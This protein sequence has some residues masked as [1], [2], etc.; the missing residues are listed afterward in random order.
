MLLFSSVNVCQL[1]FLMRVHVSCCPC[2][3]N[4]K[5]DYV[6]MAMTSGIRTS[7]IRAVTSCVKDVVSRSL[8]QGAS[9][10]GR[11]STR[12]PRAGSDSDGTTVAAPGSARDKLFSRRS[13]P[14]AKLSRQQVT[15]ERNGLI[16]ATNIDNIA[17]SRSLVY[18]VDDDPFIGIHPHNSDDPTRRKIFA[19]RCPKSRCQGNTVGFRNKP[20]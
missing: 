1:S 3:Q 14:T 8:D 19:S 15:S 5:Q 7:W 11:Q 16:T 10:D 9:V 18:Y 20:H 2:R 6:F 13:R 12:Q 4:D 17:C